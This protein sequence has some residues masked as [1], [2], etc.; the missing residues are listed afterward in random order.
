MNRVCATWQ[1]LQAIFPVSPTAPSP[2][3]DPIG[4]SGPETDL[5]K[6]NFCPSIAA[7]GLSAYALV[8]LE[9]ISGSGD[10]VF[11]VFIRESGELLHPLTTTKKH[12]QMS[13]LNID[14]LFLLVYAGA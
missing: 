1:L 7:W 8:G 10:R 14:I 11:K 4:P 5:S 13:F 6:K 2:P 9:G 3:L 12:W